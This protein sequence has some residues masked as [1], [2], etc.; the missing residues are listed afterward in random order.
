MQDFLSV[1]RLCIVCRWPISLVA[2][3]ARKRSAQNPGS[4]GAYEYGL[5]R[6][7]W[8]VARR[9]EGCRGR[10]AAV[11]LVLCV[12]CDGISPGYFFVRVLSS[13]QASL[14]DEALRPHFLRH[15]CGGP[16]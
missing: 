1:V 15:R 5:T 8:F 4:I 3:A 6:E 9:L 10:Q 16:H 2:R 14:Q 13:A 7:S 12:E 11:V